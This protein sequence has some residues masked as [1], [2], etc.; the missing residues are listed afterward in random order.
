MS[1][2]FSLQSN[3]DISDYFSLI[4]QISRLILFHLL[5]HFISLT[6]VTSLLVKSHTVAYVGGDR[7]SPLHYEFE[8][9]QKKKKY[10][11]YKQ[12]NNN[13]VLKRVDFHD[14]KE[15]QGA[16]TTEDV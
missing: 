16:V 9:R 8:A 3:S 5:R 4:L 15:M 12:T 10:P 13:I 14:L 2:I 7:Y 1:I 6:I 11:S